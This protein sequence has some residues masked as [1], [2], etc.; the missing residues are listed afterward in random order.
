MEFL[1]QPVNSRTLIE[2]VNDSDIPMEPLRYPVV[3]MP[4]AEL[5]TASA[6]SAD[7]LICSATAV[8]IREVADRAQAYEHSIEQVDPQAG[9]DTKVWLPATPYVEIRGLVKILILDSAGGCWLF[10]YG[11]NKL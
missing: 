5:L 3:S 9:M 1:M 2:E 4:A 8:A 7:A 10:L 6:S 11:L